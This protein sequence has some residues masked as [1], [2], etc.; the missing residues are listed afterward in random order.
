MPLIGGGSDADE[1]VSVE[2]EVFGV[3]R[4]Q[5]SNFEACSVEAFFHGKGYLLRVSCLGPVYYSCLLH[6]IH[7]NLS[8]PGLRIYAFSLRRGNER[9]SVEEAEGK[10]LVKKMLFSGRPRLLTSLNARHT[11]LWLGPRGIQFPVVRG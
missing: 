5:E 8:F 2:V 6:P 4:P 1:V 9:E 11:G 10:R 7:T 3:L